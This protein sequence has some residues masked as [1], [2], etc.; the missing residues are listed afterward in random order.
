MTELAPTDQQRLAAN[1]E[2]TA[3]VGANAGSGK[4][5]VLTQR[6]ARLLLAGADPAK[7]LCLTYTKAAAAEMQSRLFA[8]LGDWSMQTDARLSAMLAGLSG[9]TEPVKV[10]TLVTARRLFARA[11]E[12]PGG[13]KIQTIHAFCDALLRRF[14]LE[15]GI[16]PNFE[17]IDDRQSALMLADTRDA[18]ALEAEQS[19]DP[20]FDLIARRVNE[21]AFD[22]VVRAVLTSRD[23]LG[24]AEGERLLSEIFGDAADKTAEG[25]AAAYLATIDRRLFERVIDTLSMGSS[26]DDKAALGLRRVLDWLDVSPIKAVELL[27]K[28]VL[29]QSGQNKGMLKR[30]LPTK[31]LGTEHPWL[32]EELSDLASRAA[33]ASDDLLRQNIAARTRDLHRF[34]SAVLGRYSAAKDARSLLDFDDLITRT[35][36][37]LRDSEMRSWVLYKLDQ[38]I[39]HVLVDE[40]QDTSPRQWEVIAAITDDFHA[41]EDARAGSQALPR[42]VFV[43]GDEKQSI[44][45]F[46]GAEPVAFGEMRQRLSQ[47]LEGIG[48]ALERPDLITSFRSAPAIL[49]FV[50][51]VFDGPAAAGV[52]FTGDPV[53]HRA[54]RAGDAGRIDLWPLIEKLVSPEEPPWW[55]P[56]DTPSPDNPRDRL[57]DLLAHEIKRMVAEERLPARSAGPGRAVRPADILVLVRKRDRLARGLI[58]NLKSLGVPVAG[59]DRLSL[60]QELAVKD[61]MVLLKSVLTRSDDLSLAAA[62]RSPLCSVSEEGLF[63]LAHQRKGTLWDALMAKSEAHQRDAHMLRDLAKSAGYLAP[64]EFLER[65]LTH[66]DG[67]RRLIA[68]LGPEAEDCID[69]LLAQALTY[70]ARETPGLAGFIGWI[71]AGDVALKREMDKEAGEVRVMTIHGAKG[72]E[73]PIVIL[74]DTIS[75]NRQGGGGGGVLLP[76]GNDPNRQLTVWAGPSAADDE[77]TAAAREAAK[78]KDEAESKRLLYVG[79]TRAEDWLILCGAGNRTSADKSWYGMIEAAMACMSPVEQLPV[80]DGEIVAKRF[81][82][83]PANP[84]EIAERASDA[85]PVE[86]ETPSWL[87]AAEREARPKR[88]SPSTLSGHE[89]RA[90]PLAGLEPETARLRGVAVHLLLERLPGTSA[91]GRAQLAETLLGVEM[92]ALDEAIVSDA[93][94]EALDVM[95]EPGL[96]GIFGPRSLGEIAVSLPLGSAEALPLQGRVDRIVLGDEMV[97]IVDFKTDWS[98]PASAGEVST[99]YLAQLGAYVVAMRRIYPE[100]EVEAGLLWT[101]T[102]SLMKIGNA[103]LEAAF[104]KVLKDRTGID[105]DQAGT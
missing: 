103:A 29:G 49:D 105:L 42:S 101:R 88:V 3:W 40:A 69:E 78:E 94:R 38:G 76:V 36:D 104:S 11:L 4:T 14:P 75:S 47:R 19:T 59:S 13:L 33:A 28:A 10:E 86:T 21:D 60:A 16:S 87:K 80:G 55:E 44:Y 37:L 97:T 52:T 31:A 46:Q 84:S 77:L 9:Q 56:V 57:A 6:V 72:L 15:A 61:V 5:R 85:T 79:L 1:P 48:A 53:V 66:H 22:Q 17:V 62:L 43:V 64:Y 91:A 82:S 58:Q 24:S 18:M 7:I 89:A 98:V 39:D 96:A 74:P 95:D 8:L 83:G 70:E 45:S 20:S 54:H 26:N 50:D 81:E 2:V 51:A 99:G 102:R 41:G 67:R 30:N 92:P 68:R 63:D 71:E 73:A 12:T 65:I 35:R 25:V 32:V 90:K 100:K 34:A 27:A 93:I 23:A